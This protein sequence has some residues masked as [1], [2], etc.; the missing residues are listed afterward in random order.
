MLCVFGETVSPVKVEDFPERDR[1]TVAAGVPVEDRVQLSVCD[2]EVVS[3]GV[4]VALRVP[5]DTDRVG[6]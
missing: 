5:R 3:G 6:V 2:T 1:L 4:Y